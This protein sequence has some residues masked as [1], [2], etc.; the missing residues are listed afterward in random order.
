MQCDEMIAPKKVHT[1]YICIGHFESHCY[2]CIATLLEYNKRL[3]NKNLAGSP[4]LYIQRVLRPTMQR[5]PSTLAPTRT[6]TTTTLG[7]SQ[8][9]YIYKYHRTKED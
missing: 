9:V 1:R 2:V 3:I 4:A 8:H 6:A 7:K 5:K